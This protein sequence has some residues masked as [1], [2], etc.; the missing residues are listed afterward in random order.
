MSG[1][2]HWRNGVPGLEGID[3]AVV[4]SDLGVPGLDCWQEPRRETSPVGATET[5]RVIHRRES[6]I[7]ASYFI[8]PEGT[9][10]DLS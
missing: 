10:D 8:S 6:T 4:S 1:P 7:Y 2:Q 9:T 3:L 5:S